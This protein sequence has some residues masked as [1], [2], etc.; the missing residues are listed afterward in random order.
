MGSIHACAV[1]LG[2]DG[3]LLRGRSGAGKSTVAHALIEAWNQWNVFARLIGDDRIFLTAR[4][5][6]LIARPHNSIAGRLEVRGYGLV[7]LEHE[8]AGVIR[9]VVDLIDKKPERLPGQTDRNVMIEGVQIS[10]LQFQ[11]GT[12]LRHMV[13]VIRMALRHESNG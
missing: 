6:R 2:E 1:I 8:P 4:S 3:V 13:Q 10:A 7:D 5:G 9:L 11:A 12:D